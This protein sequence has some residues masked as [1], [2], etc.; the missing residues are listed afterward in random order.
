MK[1]SQLSLVLL[2]QPCIQSSEEI[3][4]LLLCRGASAKEAAENVSKKKVVLEQGTAGDLVASSRRTRTLFFSVSHGADGGHRS[5]SCLLQVRKKERC[6]WIGTDDWIEVGGNR[7]PKTAP[8]RLNRHLLSVRGVQSVPNFFFYIQSRR[9]CQ[10]QPWPHGDSSL[11]FTPRF[12]SL[13]GCVVSTVVQD[14]YC[15]ARFPT[16]TR[17]SEIERGEKET[18]VAGALLRATPPPALPP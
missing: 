8:V 12:H 15:V 18:L 11:L 1:E 2:L 6:R 17:H 3:A 13:V 16:R 10:S 5:S 7:Y 4:F 9:R 14:D